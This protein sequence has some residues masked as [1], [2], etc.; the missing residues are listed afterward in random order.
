MDVCGVCPVFLY[1][2]LGAIWGGGE[3]EGGRY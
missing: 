3:E 1:E 2:A